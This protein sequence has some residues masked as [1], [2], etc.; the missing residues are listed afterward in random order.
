M[1]FN[2]AKRLCQLRPV[3]RS[4]CRSRTARL[5]LEHLE[6]RRVRSGVG[7][8]HPGV[9]YPTAGT[10]Y[11]DHNVNE[12]DANPIT[13]QFGGPGSYPVPAG[14]FNG[15]GQTEVGVYYPA[16]G[17]WFIDEG[18][19]NNIEYF[20]EFQFGFPVPSPSSAISSAAASASPCL[21]PHHRYL[22]HRSQQE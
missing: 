16:S 1:F 22:V 19:Y 6:D 12:G 7:L 15:N 11:L 13:F 21:Y 5:S 10:W 18:V 2:F 8:S 20:L 9:Y 17:E 14:D 3:R 4:N